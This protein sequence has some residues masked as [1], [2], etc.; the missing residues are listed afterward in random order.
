MSQTGGHLDTAMRGYP[1][2]PVLVAVLLSPCV[3][4]AANPVAC[5]YRAVF[6]YYPILLFVVQVSK[7]LG[8]AHTDGHGLLE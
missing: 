1:I 7:F 3:Q 2:E 4:A 5:L 8:E 6:T